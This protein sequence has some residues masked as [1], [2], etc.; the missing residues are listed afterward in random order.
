[1]APHRGVNGRPPMLSSPHPCPQTKWSATKPAAEPTDPMPG[2]STVAP[3]VDATVPTP[4]L[5]KLEGL[6]S[7][8][9][10]QNESRHAA[11]RRRPGMRA[12]GRSR[13][14]RWQRCQRRGQRSGPRGR[15][16][17][18]DRRRAQ[19]TLP[20]HVCWAASSLAK[21]AMPLTVSLYLVSL[22]GVVAAPSMPGHDG[23]CLPADGRLAAAEPADDGADER[24]ALS[25]SSLIDG[26]LR[27][28][29][30]LAFP[31]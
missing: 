9:R 16:A 28:R 21:C 4:V 13:A 5:T 19:G 27:G 11:C 22:C 24:W 30:G 18:P 1:M 29:A 25:L 3:T 31:A 12:P 14:G 2:C 10:H 6:K 15:H 23:C 8:L 17:G 7:E 20:S 26:R